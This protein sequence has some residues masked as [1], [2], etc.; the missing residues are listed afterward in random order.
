VTGGAYT[1]VVLVFAKAFKLLEGSL[2][3]HFTDQV[4][5][6]R[7]KRGFCADCGSRIT[8]GETEVPQPWMGLTAS[9]LDDSSWYRPQYDIFA[10]HA[11]PWDLMDPA[12]PKHEQ[13]PPK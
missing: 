9:S 11:Q 10:S 4:S 7:H 5:G 13:Y 12:L 1:P 3:Y 2:R 6:G 8:G